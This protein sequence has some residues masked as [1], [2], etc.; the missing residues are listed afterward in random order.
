M[1]IETDI[2]SCV[3]LVGHF[4]IDLSCLY[5]FK[6]RKQKRKRLGHSKSKMDRSYYD[7]SSKEGDM[8]KRK[9][10]HD[11]PSRDTSFQEE[12]YYRIGHVDRPSSSFSSRQKEENG[13]IL[14]SRHLIVLFTVLVVIIGVGVELLFP[15]LATEERGYRQFNA[16]LWNLRK[17]FPN[18]TEQLWNVSLTAAKPVLLQKLPKH[19]AVIFLAGPKRLE[20]ITDCLARKMSKLVNNAFDVRSPVSVLDCRIYKDWG[21]DKVKQELTEKLT[22]TF[23]NGSRVAVILSVESLPG[24][25]PAILN[26]FCDAADAPFKKVA[27]ILTLNREEQSASEKD[28][29]VLK[30]GTKLQEP[31]AEERS[32]MILD[33]FTKSVAYVRDEENLLNCVA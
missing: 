20:S 7:K 11:E 24:D 28:K 30:D 13:N 9:G 18:Q 10:I 29:E 33:N 31:V 8:L 26:R 22:M 6:I 5:F 27:L 21:V 3:C 15:P 19:P 2:L 12:N 16:S 23:G 4:K 32:E 1:Q 25:S 17:T 14:F